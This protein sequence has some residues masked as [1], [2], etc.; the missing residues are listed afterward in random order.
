ME[1]LHKIII[2]VL[3]VLI[4]V[5]GVLFLTGNSVPAGEGPSYNTSALTDALQ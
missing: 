4:A 3:I 2:I 5:V 1:K